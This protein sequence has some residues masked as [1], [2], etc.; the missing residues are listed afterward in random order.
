MG[1]GASQSP[2]HLGL[3]KGGRPVSRLAPWGLAAEAKRKFATMSHRTLSER[4]RETRG[5]FSG[6]EQLP[7]RRSAAGHRTRDAG[8]GLAAL[9]SLLPAVFSKLTPP[10]GLCRH[11][12]PLLP[13]GTIYRSS[14]H[15]MERTLCLA[16]GLQETHI[17]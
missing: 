11:P 10:S 8:V 14:G 7:G 6:D 16:P 2:K 13:A 5:C 12:L 17:I 1:Q 3:G 4:L 9:S 15:P